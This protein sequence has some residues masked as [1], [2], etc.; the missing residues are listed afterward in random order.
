MTI[1]VANFDHD[2]EETDLRVLFEKFGTVN[3]VHICMD[4]RTGDPLGYGFIEMPFD[5]DAEWAI[6]KLDGRRWNGRRLKV[7]EKQDRRERY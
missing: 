4:S 1:F 3:D 7:S 5:R 2:T 6:E